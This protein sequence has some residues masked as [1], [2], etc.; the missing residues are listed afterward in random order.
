MPAALVSIRDVVD[1]A[2]RNGLLAVQRT[3]PRTF[4]PLPGSKLAKRIGAAGIN[5][6]LW[7]LNLIE[8]ANSIA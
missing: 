5:K 1:Y 8:Y 2:D 4:V 6:R 7:A 3:G